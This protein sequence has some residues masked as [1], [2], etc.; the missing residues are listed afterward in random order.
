MRNN[1]N[2]RLRVVCI[3]LSVVHVHVARRSLTDVPGRVAPAMSLRDCRY[4]TGNISST[5][6]LLEPRLL[7]FEVALNKTSRI[8]SSRGLH[9][10]D[11]TVQQFLLQQPRMHPLDEQCIAYSQ[12]WSCDCPESRDP[13]PCVCSWRAK[14]ATH[15]HSKR[16]VTRRGFGSL[17][18]GVFMYTRCLR[19]GIVLKDINNLIHIISTTKT[20]YCCKLPIASI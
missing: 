20:I 14:E 15:S 12:G 7:Q 17:A 4:A 13:R 19:L 2:G 6:T 10:W 9:G 8:S 11:S 18:L 16:R 3:R 1:S 5:R